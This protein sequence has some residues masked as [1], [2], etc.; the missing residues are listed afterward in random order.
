MLSCTLYS[1][2]AILIL[3][4]GLMTFAWDEDGSIYEEKE[5]K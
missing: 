1:D 4:D 2:R 3:S 5:Q